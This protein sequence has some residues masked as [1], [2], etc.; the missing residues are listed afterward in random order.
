MILDI[1]NKYSDIIAGYDIQKFRIVGT[2]YQL[3]CRIE[4]SAQFQK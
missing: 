4:L 2:S 1:I 3:V